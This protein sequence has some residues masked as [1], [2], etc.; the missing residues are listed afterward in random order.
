MVQKKK[1]LITIQ[2]PTGTGKTGAALLLAAKYPMEII[3]ADSMQFYRHMD[4]GTSKPT[5][6]E[7]KIVPHHLFSI[8]NPDEGFDA[9]MFMEKGRQA[10]ED[11]SSR[12]G[13]PLAVGGT[14]LYLKA[15]TKGLF[16]VPP[17]DEKL[18]IKLKELSKKQLFEKLKK[19]DP[20][21]SIR[22]NPNDLVRVIRA[23]EVFH[24]TGVPFSEHQKKHGFNE[25]VYDC[26]KICVTKTRQSLYKAI[27]HRV[28]KMLEQGFLE[29]VKALL[30]KGYSPTDKPLQ[31][32]GYKQMIEHIA[33]R[34]SFKEAVSQMK[35]QSKR[36]AKRQLTWFRKDPCLVWVKLPEESN[37]LET[38]VK[39]FLKLR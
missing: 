39:K 30:G 23:I 19:I 32:I 12:G 29:E 25:D 8:V 16:S 27:E 13:V 31:S 5:P 33:G 37:R 21:A 24:L 2:G 35:M 3:N 18:R 6:E 20:A 7:Q 4:I 17:A 14:G 38:L 9:A 15:L 10:I 22:I 36:L 11:I 34:L 1:K 28:N 26:L